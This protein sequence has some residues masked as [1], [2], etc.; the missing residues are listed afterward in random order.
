MEAIGL[1]GP[2]RVG[3]YRVLSVLGEGGMGRVLLA[4]AP[5]GRLV[6][7][8]QVHAR[9]ADDGDFRAR[10][11]REVAASQKVSG[12]Y[13]AAVMDADVDAP[14]PW[15]ASVFVPG[16]SL[17]AAVAELGALPERTVRR[18]AAGLVTALTEIHRAGLIHRDLK[19]ENVLLTQ[20]GVRVIDLGIARAAE[21]GVDTRL[22]RTGLV[23]GSPAFMSP[24]QAEGRALTPAS[25]V[26]SLG[27]V[28]AL[29][30][31][32]AS[33]FAADSML[34][35]L[36]NL[37][38]AEPELSSVPA[39]LRPLVARCLAK[40]P[41]DRPAPA[42]LLHLLGTVPPAGRLPWP[43]AVHGMIT[44]QG[45]AIDRLL[46]VDP[47]SDPAPVPEPPR[48]A[49]RVPDPRIPAPP[50]ARPQAR[51]AQPP[52]PPSTE[53]LGP[54]EEPS[55]A[56]E[57]NREDGRG[58]APEP[59]RG[60]GPGGADGPQRVEGPP[61]PGAGP[62]GPAPLLPRLRP[63]SGPRPGPP[64]EPELGPRPGPPSEPGPEPESEPE[65]SVS[66]YS[67]TSAVPPRRRPAART[68]VLAAV[69]VLA[70]A[71]LGAWGISVARSG[72][73]DPPA[74][75]V[76]DKYATLADCSAIAPRLPLLQSARDSAKDVHSETASGAITSCA[77]TQERAAYASV[78]WDLELGGRKRSGTEDQRQRY[79]EAVTE[80][81]GESGIGDEAFWNG[82]CQLVVRDGNVMVTV[83]LNGGQTA[84]A[85]RP[86]VKDIARAALTLTGG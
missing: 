16:P 18:L 35:T 9:L 81:A 53:R 23:I 2:E 64:S 14:T 24:E 30:A 28:L 34:R 37:V 22:T 67:V 77:W 85:C 76:K 86:Q 17:G 46:G 83:W 8:K 49:T 11:R 12:A 58:R 10:F 33:P 39:E 42:E 15:L 60:A 7:V 43:P 1:S 79:A 48:P 63:T 21:S 51:L 25:D 40:A 80:G 78:D 56:D 47:D 70:V 45:A 52:E 57:P 59:P 36:F 32:G 55:R 50:T 3:P 66:P 27:S 75:R 4:A 69:A 20:D 61:P 82:A 68:V 31:T 62:A 71:G 74:A 72:A 41:A 54:A 44:A 38:H 6:A 84:D 19:P 26:F 5:D 73:G 65:S 13:T 29:A